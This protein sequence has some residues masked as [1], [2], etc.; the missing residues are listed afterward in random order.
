MLLKDEP[1]RRLDFTPKIRKL[2]NNK[3]FAIA[4]NVKTIKE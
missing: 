2:I 3:E 1:A 4:I